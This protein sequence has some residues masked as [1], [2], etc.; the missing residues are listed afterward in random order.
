MHADTRRHATRSC[1]SLAPK[2]QRDAQSEMLISMK[3]HTR[4]RQSKTERRKEKDAPTRGRKAVHDN[5]HVVSRRARDQPTACLRQCRCRA[6]E[7]QRAE[8]AGIRLDAARQPAAVTL[9]VTS[10]LAC[11]H[12]GDCAL[13]LSWL[14]CHFIVDHTRSTRRLGAERCAVVRKNMHAGAA[15]PKYAAR[16]VDA[17]SGPRRSTIPDVNLVARVRPTLCTTNTD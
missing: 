4:V 6:S 12:V 7:A 14:F 16:D 1:S 8:A 15:K 10:C 13:W 9:L 17:H 2:V 3:T 5:E 11:A